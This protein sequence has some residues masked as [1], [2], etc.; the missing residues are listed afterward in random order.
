MQ[1]EITARPNLNRFAQELT[2]LSESLV[3]DF[4]WESLIPVIQMGVEGQFASEGGGG[5]WPALSLP[6]AQWKAKRYP[7]K[8]LLQREGVYLRA[9]TT[10]G[11]PYNFVETG[12]DY[13]KYGVSG[14][15]Y[16]AFH[17]TGAGN[18]PQRAVFSALAG[19]EAFGNAVTTIFRDWIARRLADA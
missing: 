13:I 7:G 10:R 15:D 19:D 12:Q 3:S 5:Q 11:A 1:I 18:L 9:A 4:D 17:E 16:A 2:Q 14:L 6:Y 8:G